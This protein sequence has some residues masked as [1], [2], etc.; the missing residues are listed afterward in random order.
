MQEDG[1]IQILYNNGETAFL[2][3]SNNR[4]KFLTNLS[5][6]NGNLEVTYNT[7]NEQEVP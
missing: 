1:L 3:D 5:L 6:I 7:L 2:N 4:I